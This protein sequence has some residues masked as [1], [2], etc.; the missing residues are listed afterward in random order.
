MGFFGRKHFVVS[1]AAHRAVMS[2]ANSKGELDIS[3]LRQKARRAQSQVH[4]PRYS[5]NRTAYGP[6]MRTFAKE[7]KEVSDWVGS[8]PDTPFDIGPR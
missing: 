8:N 3:A 2:C 6:E 4:S 5:A 1:K 7:L